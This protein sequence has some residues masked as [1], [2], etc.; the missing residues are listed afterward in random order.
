MNKNRTKIVIA[1]LV[2]FGLLSCKKDDVTTT[3]TTTTIT[4]SGPTFEIVKISETGLSNFDRKIVVFGI[5]IYAAPKVEDIKLTHAAHVM[6]QYL[7]NDENGIVDNQLVI[8]KM[9]ENKAFL[10]MWKTESDMPTEEIA[11]RMAQDLGA[12]ETNPDFVKDG[13]SGRFDASLEEVWH[14][15][16]QAGHAQ[17][18]PDV[19]GLKEG[20]E[21][22]NAMDIARGGKFLTIPAQYPEEA[23]YTYDDQT[24]DYADCQTI[25]YMYWAMSSILGAQENRLNDIEHEWKLNT[26]S[27]VQSKD[28]KVYNLLTNS[29]YKFP[30]KLPDGTYKK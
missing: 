17:A 21:L 1:L 9:I 23:W 6:A 26:P 29:T 11:G 27:L 13:K 12:D 5:D 28:S 16:N 18:Y 10:F 24:C 30:T 20:S 19:F 7:D 15:I 2:S 4:A 22:A 8:N 3:T 14:L 25:E